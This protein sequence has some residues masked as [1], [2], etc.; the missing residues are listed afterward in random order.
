MEGHREA[1]RLAVAGLTVVALDREASLRRLAELGIPSRLFASA[2]DDAIRLALASA[3]IAAD[4]AMRF[5]R[6]NALWRDG[7][8]E[9]VPE[10]E[11]VD[12][13]AG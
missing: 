1:D 9:I 3:E 7:G 2:S 8:E 6:L 11:L 5:G 12:D 13:P 4:H 10:T